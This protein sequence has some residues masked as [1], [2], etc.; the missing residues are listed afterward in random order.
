MDEK[1]QIQALDRTQPSLPIKPGRAGTMTH[2]YKRNGTTTLRRHLGIN[3]DKDCRHI[4][5]FGSQKIVRYSDNAY[6]RMKEALDGGVDMDDVWTKHGWGGPTAQCTE[7]VT[8]R[9]PRDKPAPAAQS[10]SAT[11]HCAVRAIAFAVPAAHCG[12]LLRRRF[13]RR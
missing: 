11:N 8:R 1:S 5:E 6:R 3:D 9:T 7:P 2:D 4:F 10:R 12:R 13:D